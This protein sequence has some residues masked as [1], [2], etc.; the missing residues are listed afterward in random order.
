MTTALIPIEN[1]VNLGR[2]AW[3][4]NQ[5]Q[6]VGRER[7]KFI[8]LYDSAIVLAGR[9]MED[10][11]ERELI[12]QL[13]R[14]IR[15]ATRGAPD[16]IGQDSVT[17]AGWVSMR[18]EMMYNAMS[19][20]IKDA[21]RKLAPL[22][23]PDRGGSNEL[24]Q[25]ALSAYRLKDLTYLQ[26]LYIQLAQDNVFW[27][28]SGEASKYIETELQRPKVSLLRLQN[29]PE[30]Q[31]VMLDRQGKPDVAR[32]FASVIA[33]R[34]IIVLQAELHYI[35]TGERSPQ[36]NQESK[37]GNDEN[38][39]QESNGCRQSGDHD[40]DQGWCGGP[41]GIPGEEDRHC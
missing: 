15:I 33:K 22:V 37:D 21:W 8:R 41:E 6:R 20:M 36:P 35:V 24:F 25:M 38:Q 9:Y 27:R 1:Q 40:E 12:L 13:R 19:H 14:D 18:T 39:D 2:L 7:Q 26:D 5:L 10:L 34:L 32:E 29:K 3:Y 28:C 16:T 30:F 31:I 11:P 4:A 23:H 17:S